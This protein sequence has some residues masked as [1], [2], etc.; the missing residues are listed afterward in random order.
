L[1]QLHTV[2]EGGIDAWLLPCNLAIASFL[3]PTQS[4]GKIMPYFFK[5][6][7]I[8]FLSLYDPANIAQCWIVGWDKNGK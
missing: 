7:L 3:M 8:C 1:T 2:G 5:G 6:G 4:Y